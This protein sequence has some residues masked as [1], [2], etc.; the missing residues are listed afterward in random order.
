M[1]VLIGAAMLLAGLPGIYFARQT[2]REDAMVQMRQKTKLAARNLDQEY[3]Q[4]KDVSKALEAVIR[5]SFKPETDFLNSN[6]LDQF[7]QK[8]IPQFSEILNLMR[9]MSL[10]MVFNTDQVNG[11]H[12]ISFYDKTG[13]GNYT[14]APEYNIANRD[15]AQQSMEW[16]T[17]AVEKGEVWTSP[18]FWREWNMQIVSY[19]KAIYIDS[20][21]IGCLGSD[22]NFDIMARQLDALHDFKSGQPILFDDA[23]K[24]IYQGNHQNHLSPER[25]T[26]FQNHLRETDS[27]IF[28]LNHDNKEYIVAFETLQNGWKIALSVSEKEIF[29]R[30]NSL[31]YSLIIVFSLVFI[32]VLILAFYFSKYITSPI[33]SLLAKF[34]T[35]TSGDLSVRSQI[36]TKDEMKELSDHFNKM[37]DSL[38]Y[39]F[40]ELDKTQKILNREKNRAEESDSLK[41]SFLENLSHEIR[42]PLMAIVGFSELMTDRSSTPEERQDFF[43]HIAYN[44]DLLIR[45]IEDT[46]LF[47]Q[48]EKDQ[49]PVRK[50]RFKLREVL[51][52]LNEEFDIRRKKDKPQLYFRILCDECEEAEMDTD[53]G[54]LRRLIRY[55]LDNAFKFTDSGG[56]TLVCRQNNGHLEINVSDSGI[57][58]S[59][60]KTDI[61]FRKFCKVMESSD[62][63]YDGAGIGLT[64]ARGIALLLGGTIELSSSRG[65]GTTVTVSFP[66]PGNACS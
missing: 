9:P 18:Y 7:E 64:N 19:S 38:Q 57:G 34:K 63:V 40:E 16:W 52:D 25:K 15:L 59:D 10:W 24:I 8:I 62:R 3:S 58:I 12:T 61:V 43:T 66:M 6:T 11:K 60:D 49:V 26:E 17:K 47:S 45:F 41:S 20:L 44:S 46:L 65:E 32:V 28:F 37:M 55:L 21:F 1:A 56:I 54:L 30:V 36:Q 48:L 31:I 50:S 33:H 5:S 13:N 27:D 29:A 39:S 42:T 51:A 53:K 2:A 35:A 14:R 23:N 22:F 4:L